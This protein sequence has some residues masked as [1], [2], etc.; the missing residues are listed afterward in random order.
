[1]IEINHDVQIK[2]LISLPFSTLCHFQSAIRGFLV[3]HSSVNTQDYP[4]TQ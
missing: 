2:T 4:L 1:M 3:K